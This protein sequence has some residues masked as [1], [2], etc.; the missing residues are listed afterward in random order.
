MTLSDVINSPAVSPDTIVTVQLAVST[1]T[2][3]L[4]EEKQVDM[5]IWNRRVEN[6]A[7]NA[8]K[9]LIVQLS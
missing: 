4:K 8:K 6:Y 2:A 9:G 3:D 5:D 7:W 1:I